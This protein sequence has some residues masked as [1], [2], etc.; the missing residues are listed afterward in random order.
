MNQNGRETS[1]G[2]DNYQYFTKAQFSGLCRRICV[3]REERRLRMV[4]VI[5]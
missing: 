2:H 4:F 3:L 1:R 5:Y